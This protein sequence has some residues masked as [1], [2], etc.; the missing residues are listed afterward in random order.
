ML[1]FETIAQKIDH[2]HQLAEKSAVNALEHAYETGKLLLEMKAKLR[3]G[4]FQGWILGQHT[5]IS[6]RKAQRYMSFVVGKDLTV[7]KLAGKSDTVSH[8]SPPPSIHL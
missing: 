4:E 7:K 3:H 8:L 6:I 1:A 5:Q 2:H